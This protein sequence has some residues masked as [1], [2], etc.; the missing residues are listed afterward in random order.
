MERILE[1]SIGAF[2]KTGIDMKYLKAIWAF[3][4]YLF[5]PQFRSKDS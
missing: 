1:R 2:V 4:S 5:W 3:C